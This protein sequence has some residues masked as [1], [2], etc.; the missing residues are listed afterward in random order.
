MVR[1]K[2][3]GP[4]VL[5]WPKLFKGVVFTGFSGDDYEFRRSDGYGMSETGGYEGDG[6]GDTA[7]GN[8]DGNGSGSGFSVKATGNGR[9]H[10]HNDNNR[11]KHGP[12]R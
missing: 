9:G 6:W 8:G 10:G 11:L 4:C 12:P 2:L 3:L 5:N 1:L 7:W